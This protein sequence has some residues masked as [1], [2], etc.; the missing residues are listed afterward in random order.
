MPARSRGILTLDVEDWEHANFAQLDG[1]QEEIARTVRERHYAMDANT[2]RWIL[3]WERSKSSSTCF[4]LGEFARRY[5]GA[6]KRLAAAGH[7][8]A[9]HGDTHDLIYR[10]SREQFREFLKRGLGAVGE[11]TGRVPIGFRAPSWSVD[12]ERTPWFL[13]ELQAAGLRYDSSEFPIRTTLYG[14]AGARLDPYWEGG[15][16]RVPV[17]VLSVGSLRAPFA[18]GAFFRL[19]PLPLIKFGLQRAA[20]QGLPAMVVLHPRELDPQHPRLKIRG[21]EGVIHY[22]L[23]GTVIPKLE[24][25][26]DAFEWGSIESVYAAEILRPVPLSGRDRA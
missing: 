1:A 18:S 14:Q 23:L 26:R 2:D 7:E 22:A 4:V 6:V 15:L 9:S 11:L 19:S 10:M 21:W 5:P 20:K 12:R 3:I 8:I 16:F 25:L 13:E 17:T 24:A